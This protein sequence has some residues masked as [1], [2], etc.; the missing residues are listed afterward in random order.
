MNKTVKVK[1]IFWG[2][3]ASFTMSAF[4]LIVMFLTMTPREVWFN[5]TEFWYLMVGIIIGFGIQIGLWV[6]V[7]NYGTDVHNTVPGVGG[8]MSGTAMVTCCVHHLAD[9]LPVLGI[10]GIA[11]FLAQYQKPFLVL[12]VSTNLL[13]IAYMVHLIQKRQ[14]NMD[15]ISN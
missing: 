9:V 14:R 10:S 1:V 3:I 11:I 8:A 4:Y 15:L 13:G 7:K 5:F 2:S 12:G 6:Y